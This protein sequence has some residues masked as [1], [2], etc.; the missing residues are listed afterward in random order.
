MEEPLADRDAR[1]TLIPGA[2]G[3]SAFWD[4]IAQCL[5]SNF[6]VLAFDLPGLGNFPAQSGI[7]SYD[8]LA[9]YVAAKIRGSSAVVGQSMGAYIALQLALRYPRRVT[10]LVMTAATGGVDALRL[11]AADWRGDYAT[12]YPNAASWARS[13]VRDLSDD[14]LSRITIPV[15]LLWPTRDGLSP[16]SIAHR[17][18]GRL[19]NARL[20]TFDS[21]DHWFVHHFADHIASEIAEFI[22]PSTIR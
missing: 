22:R 14:A 5:D 16:L 6:D 18:A 21:D 7:A 15:L 9:D 4:P 10:H 8:D 3:S 17:L 20:V 12:T 19:P 1:V 2:A 13:H 11:G